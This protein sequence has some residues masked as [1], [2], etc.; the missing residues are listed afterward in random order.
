MCVCVYTLGH[1]SRVRLFAAPWTVSHQDTP[2]VR[3]ILQDTAVGCHA[4]HQGI[5]PTQGSNLCLTSPALGG[6]FFITSAT[7]EAQ[8]NHAFVPKY[9]FSFK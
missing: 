5:F 4:L 7:W 6:R 8:Y 9:L 2:S 3:G 1:F